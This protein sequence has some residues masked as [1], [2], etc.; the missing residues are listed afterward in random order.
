MSEKALTSKQQLFV[1]E[2]LVDLNAT[3]A[4]IRAGYSEKTAGVLQFFQCVGVKT[5][6]PRDANDREL[7]QRHAPELALI[8][9]HENPAL[10][11]LDADPDAE[12]LVAVDP[13]LVS[14]LRRLERPN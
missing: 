1:D 10:R 14:P 5:V 2:Y 7:A 13:L 3:Q 6:R 8:P 4:A 12:P 11:A 9:V